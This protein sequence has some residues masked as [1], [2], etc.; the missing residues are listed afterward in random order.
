MLKQDPPVKASHVKEARS[1]QGEF[2]GWSALQVDYKIIAL[3]EV[4][5]QFDPHVVT[6]W[7]SED[8]YADT[9][10]KASPPDLRNAV[11]TE[12]VNKR[13]TIGA[14]TATPTS[15]LTSEATVTFNYTLH[16]AGAPAPTSE[17]VQFLD[18]I[19][20]IGSAQTIGSISASNACLIRKLPLGILGS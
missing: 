5:L 17:P 15:G 20:A 2:V 12:T 3:T 1:R 16:T 4:I 14:L 13:N 10:R 6:C 9:V 11:L 7:L 19:T 18:G 8:E